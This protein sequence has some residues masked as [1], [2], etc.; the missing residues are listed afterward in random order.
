[1]DSI[2]VLFR[3]FLH[4]FSPETSSEPIYITILRRS[5]ASIES[6]FIIN[7]QHIKSFNSDLSKIIET[8]FYE[9]QEQLISEENGFYRHVYPNDESYER[10]MDGFKNPSI[11]TRIKE[12]HASLCGHLVSFQAFVTKIWYISHE[13][14]KAFHKCL[15]CGT[16]NLPSAHNFILTNV[17]KCSSKVCNNRRQCEIIPEKSTITPCQRIVVL[18]CNIEV[19]LESLPRTIE[20]ILRNN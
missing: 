3:E 4:R 8:N 12:L 1:M 9:Y 19:K 13:I 7:I 20:V 17:A 11:K 18:E 15:K 5:I 10:V 16:E 14:T 6:N 2:Q